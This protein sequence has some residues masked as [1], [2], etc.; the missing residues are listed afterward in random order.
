MLG[1][2]INPRINIGVGESS[3]LPWSTCQ[4][5]PELCTVLQILV[6]HSLPVS[7]KTQSSFHFV[8]FPDMTHCG[9]HNHGQVLGH[10]GG[11]MLCVRG[12]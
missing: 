3:L 9:E 7:T 11:A 1:G 8:P 5:K 6:L 10:P 2:N 4:T 12:V